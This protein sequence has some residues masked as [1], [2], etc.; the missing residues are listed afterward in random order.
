MAAFMIL[1]PFFTYSWTFGYAIS[2]GRLT[3]IQKS[4]CVH[5]SPA[6]K[7]RALPIRRG[8]T[9]YEIGILRAFF[10]FSLVMFSIV[11]LSACQSSQPLTPLFKWRTLVLAL[12]APFAVFG[13]LVDS[14]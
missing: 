8:T 9:S 5:S 7:W 3:V 2:P 14:A 6:P 10:F 4:W 12:P 13:A 1:A 11:N